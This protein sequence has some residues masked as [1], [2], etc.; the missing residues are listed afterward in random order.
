MYSRHGSVS[1]QYSYFREIPLALSYKHIIDNFFCNEYVLLQMEFL[2]LAFVLP[3]A[4]SSLSQTMQYHWQNL[5]PGKTLH[6]LPY[7]PVVTYLWREISMFR[8]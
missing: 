4:T 7:D 3:Q 5:C 2:V 1:L 8:W 6:L